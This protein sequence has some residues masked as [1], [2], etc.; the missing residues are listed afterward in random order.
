M[1]PTARKKVKKA[2]KER[3]TSNKKKNSVAQHKKEHL[4]ST[5]ED[6]KHISLRN[7]TEPQSVVHAVRNIRLECIVF[8]LTAFHA[9][10][11]KNSRW[12]CSVI[13][14]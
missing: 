6:D 3:S 12:M 8:R 7:A 14:S 10:I 1:D 9:L 11:L 13:M 2:S 4:Q 5:L